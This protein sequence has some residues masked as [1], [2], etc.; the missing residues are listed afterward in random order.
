MKA[1]AADYHGNGVL[2]LLELLKRIFDAN[3]L[4]VMSSAERN[5]G[6]KALETA[7]PG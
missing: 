3:L 1:F 4:R 2:I 5:Y 7:M 6:P